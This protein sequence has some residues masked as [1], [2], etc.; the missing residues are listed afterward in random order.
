M[1]DDKRNSRHL[2]YWNSYKEKVKKYKRYGKG[3]FDGLT[4][5]YI[6]EDLALK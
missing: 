3:F 6:R 1:S 2:Q 5:K 4:G